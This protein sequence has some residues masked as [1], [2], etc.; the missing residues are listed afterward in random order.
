MTTD[1]RPFEEMTAIAKQAK[2]QALVAADDYFNFL[3]KTISSHPSGGTEFGKGLERSCRKEHHCGSGIRPQ[4][5][6]SKGFS[7]GISSSN[8][9]HA[10]SIRCIKRRNKKPR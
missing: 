3:R 6:R 2:E 10:V 1:T 8:R 4:T 7:G 9:I 5:Q